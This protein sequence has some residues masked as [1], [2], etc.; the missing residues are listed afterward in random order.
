[1]K[2]VF[3]KT[4][5][6]S[7]LLALCSVFV[8]WVTPVQASAQ[9]DSDFDCAYSVP[10]GKPYFQYGASEVITYTQEEAKAA[11]VPD[12]YSGTV[13]SVKPVSSSASGSGVLLDFSA[14]EM[15][16]C[17]VEH[18]AVRFYLGESDKNT[19]GRPQLRIMSPITD[20]WVYQPEKA[21][22]TGEWATETIENTDSV[23]DQLA[24]EKGCLDKF[25]LS[26]RVTEHVDFYI[27]SVTLKLLENDGVGPEI[28]C[29][30]DSLT[31]AVGG[32][33]IL[34]A[35]A[36]DAQEKCE[37]PLEYIWESGVELG[38]N[39]APTKAGEYVLTL[40]AVDYHGNESTKTIAVTVI[41]LDREKPVI[42]LNF[43]VMYAQVGM[44]PT[45]NF[46]VTDNQNVAEVTRTWSEG[47][48]DKKGALTEGTHT[49]TVTAKDDS[50]NV[51]T[52][53]VTVIVTKDEHDF[54]N[55]VDEEALSPRYAV[56]F[57]GGNSETYKYGEKVKNPDEPV[58]EDTEE[59]TYVFEGWYNGDA[60]WD[61]EKDVVVSDM[62]LVAKWTEIPLSQGGDDTASGSADSSVP[63]QSDDTASGSADS[64]VPDQSG[65]SSSV[66]TGSGNSQSSGGCSGFVG[67]V[68]GNVLA[69]GV[70][71]I[72]LRKKKEN[73]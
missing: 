44:I 33:F 45:L 58:R 67:G 29:E 22:V 30:G 20:D 28:R 34:D 51:A 57:D 68:A 52:H 10:T 23:F 19:G 47:A 39:G 15:P 3:K 17:M 18:I 40:R 70:A 60:A 5:L 12:G 46:E 27:D 1:M 2:K 9:T 6:V 62:N 65:N 31:V 4:S 50:D 16:A 63:D 64:S 32:N 48:L 24:N 72:T 49:Y 42:H 11:G 36:Y 66:S 21:S 43:T 35:T 38:E 69:L 73:K 26:V 71:V 13:L 59:Y 25:E 61:F 7:C 37:K 14:L 56:T 8:A 53:T 41:E 54:D 55:V